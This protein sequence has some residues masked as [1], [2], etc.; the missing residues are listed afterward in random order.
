[1]LLVPLIAAYRKGTCSLLVSIS[2]QSL[3]RIRPLVWAAALKNKKNTCQLLARAQHVQFAPQAYF[4]YD[5][6][7][8]LSICANVPS[9]V[10]LAH[11]LTNSEDPTFKKFFPSGTCCLC[12]S[13]PFTTMA[14]APLW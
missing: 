10:L 5:I 6:A 14:P 4:L 7:L 1:M 9:L 3:S 12:R 2:P 11:K 8:L 13:S